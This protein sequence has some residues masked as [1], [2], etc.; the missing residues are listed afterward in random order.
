MKTAT[1]LP[2]IFVSGFPNMD[3]MDLDSSDAPSGT[4]RKADDV[5]LDVSAPRRIK[6][7][8]TAFLWQK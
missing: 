7:P 6:V 4:K 1:I 8:I 3:P 2:F 5:P